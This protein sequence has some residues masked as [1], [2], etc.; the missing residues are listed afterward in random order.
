VEDQHTAQEREKTIPNVVF[1]FCNAIFVVF[2]LCLPQ[3][4]QKNMAVFSFLSQLAQE[5]RAL[6]EFSTKNLKTTKHNIGMI[7]GHS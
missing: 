4:L 5:G 6:L 3:V 2:F 7:V 1:I